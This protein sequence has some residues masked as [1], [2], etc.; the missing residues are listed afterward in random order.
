MSNW[1]TVLAA[2]VLLGA[3]GLIAAHDERA[4]IDHAHQ[5]YCQRVV[6]HFN[7]MAYG[8]PL[9]GHHDY[10]DKCSDADIEQAREALSY[11]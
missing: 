4:Q 9:L 8:G 3:L 5:D 2:V 10:E 7:S 11:E 6:I 1:I